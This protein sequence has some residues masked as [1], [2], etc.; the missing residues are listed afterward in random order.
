MLSF[1]CK[2]F[3]YMK[4]LLLLSHGQLVHYQHILHLGLSCGIDV[5]ALLRNQTVIKLVYLKIR[6]PNK[7]WNGLKGGDKLILG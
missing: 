5:Y 6:S 2:S 3:S 1:T 4:I 7:T